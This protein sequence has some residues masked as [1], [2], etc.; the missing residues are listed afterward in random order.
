M[1]K[2]GQHLRG[3]ETESDIRAGITRGF[4]ELNDLLHS[5]PVRASKNERHGFLSPDLSLLPSLTPLPH[6]PPQTQ[7]ID[8]TLSGTTAIAIL[9]IGETMYICNVGDSRAILAQRVGPASSNSSV[10]RPRL[11]SISEAAPAEAGGTGDE[12]AANGGGDNGSSSGSN[13]NPPEPP[14]P[15]ELKAYPLSDDQTPYRK[16]ERE[17]VKKSGYV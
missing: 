15:E 13:V 6:P 8:D 16:D 4:L 11:N 14:V 1:E 12:A 2:L 3:K 17:R 5:C 9:F 7:G 10:A